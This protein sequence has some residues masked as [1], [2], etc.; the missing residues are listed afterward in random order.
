MS[1]LGF[2]FI[3]I[4]TVTPK[5]QFGNKKPRIFRIEK[6]ESLLNSLGFNNKGATYVKKKLQALKR[7]DI[8]IGANIGPNKS[9]ETNKRKEDYS[10]CFNELADYVDYIVLNISSPNTPDLRD[11]HNIENLKEIIECILIEKE[12]INYSGKIFLKLSP[13]EKKSKTE[14]VIN[15]VNSMDIDGVIASNTSDDNQLKSALGV[16]QKPGGISGK[17]LKN[18]SNELL[19]LVKSKIEPKKIIVAVGGVFD[20]DSYNEKLDLGAD[21]VQMYTGLI[22][23][24]PNQVREIIRNGK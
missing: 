19:K 7:K 15:L 1:N 2:G 21:L 24:G 12:N 22:Y 10:Y 6:E 17:P 14:A 13:D 18:K 11:L 23:E 16:S 9:T 3:E 20:V 4:G 8:V 5:K